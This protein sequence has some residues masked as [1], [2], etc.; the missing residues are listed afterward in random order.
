MGRAAVALTFIFFLCVAAAA[1]SAYRL[2]TAKKKYR[3]EGDYVEV[4]IWGEPQLVLTPPPYELEYEGQ[5]V[6]EIYAQYE[7]RVR[8]LSSELVVTACEINITWYAALLSQ[9]GKRLSYVVNRTTEKTA[10]TTLWF[11]V[12]SSRLTERV[13]DTPADGEKLSIDILLLI[14]VEA[15]LGPTR[16]TVKTYTQHI[17]PVRWVGSN[18]QEDTTTTNTYEAWREGWRSGFRDG[19]ND[20]RLRKPPAHTEEDTEPYSPDM[21]E[22]EA[23]R[24]GYV[25]GYVAGYEAYKEIKPEIDRTDIG[26]I[27]PW[28]TAQPQTDEATQAATQLVVSV[29][30]ATISGL[31]QARI[32]RR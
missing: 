1:Y 5:L 22:E 30:A 15:W 13:E 9:D 17:F 10:S 29:V 19:W 27:K 16:D 23:R 31:I 21:D 2:M 25:S 11:A 24:A 7:I 6:D 18:I 12:T 28:D 4:L 26:S 14:S 3:A 8:P 32:R 20:A